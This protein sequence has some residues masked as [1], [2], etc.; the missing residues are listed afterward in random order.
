MLEPVRKMKLNDQ[1]MSMVKM[2]SKNMTKPFVTEDYH[3]EYQ[4]KL[5][6]A[7]MKK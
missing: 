3:D 1:E 7:I 4:E 2:L 6:K 5:R